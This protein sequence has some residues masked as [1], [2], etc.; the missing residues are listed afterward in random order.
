MSGKG[1]PPRVREDYLSDAQNLL[2]LSRAVKADEKR[3]AQWRS[4]VTEGLKELAEKL[5]KA[6]AVDTQLD[7][8]DKRK[9]T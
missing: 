4:E 3:P 8:I 5:I 1:R 2:H 7:L 9:D 6:P